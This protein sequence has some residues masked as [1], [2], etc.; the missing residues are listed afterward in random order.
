MPLDMLEMGTKPGF[1]WE[2]RPLANHV[3]EAGSLNTPVSLQTL[4][5]AITSMLKLCCHPKTKALWYSQQCTCACTAVHNV[6]TT[7]VGYFEYRV[8]LL[9]S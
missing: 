7:A 4:T 3:P 6:V 8:M 2:L 1:V 5:V 9:R